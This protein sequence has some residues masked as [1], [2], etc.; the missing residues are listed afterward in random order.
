MPTEEQLQQRMEEI[1]ELGVQTKGRS[2]AEQLVVAGRSDLKLQCAAWQHARNA[3]LFWGRPKQLAVLDPELP[4]W[5]PG[6]RFLWRIAM[7]LA[8]RGFGKSLTGAQTAWHRIESGQARSLCFIGPD[9]KDTRRAMVGGLPDTDSGFLDVLPPEVRAETEWNKNDHEIHVHSHGAT[10]YLNTANEPE[11]RSGNFDFV[12]GDEP[13]KWRYLEDVMYNLLQA[14]RRP[15]AVAP[16][17]LLTT[18]PK[19]QDWL[20][21]LVLDP[22]VL[23][24]H[25]EQ[26]ENRSNLSDFFL[27]DQ[28]QRYGGTRIGEQECRG[29]L[30]GANED[31][32][33]ASGVIER[34]R[35]GTA[36]K[37]AEVGVGIDPAVSTKRRSDDSGIVAA[38]RGFDDHLYVLED[39]SDSYGANEW[40]R[41]A[42]KVAKD[43]GAKFV[44]VERNKIGD[45]G[46]ELVRQALVALGLEGKIEIR[47]AYAAP[48]RDKWTRALPVGVLYEQ[49]RVHHVGR[50]PPLETQLTQWDPSVSK[51]SPNNLDAYVHVA[52]AVMHLDKPMADPSSSL[53]GFAELNKGLGAPDGLGGLIAG[54]RRGGGGGRTI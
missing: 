27:D 6:P 9:W 32:L 46:V 21:E 40:P 36:P 44:I 13:I 42:A 47:E 11:Q 49:E 35:V 17:M 51:V 30:L 37:L 28:E 20:I 54:I 12:W 10:I 5:W 22:S 25:G 3:W 50:F 16:Q 29:R 1:Y 18:T 23:V 43:W 45:A 52:V 8:G 14:L 15:R 7:V 4:E 34:L 33:V 48:G 19:R 2:V 53:K 31:A 41:V 38:G 39:R 24:I 26:D